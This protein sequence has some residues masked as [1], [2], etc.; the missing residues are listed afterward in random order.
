[1][2]KSVRYRKE[3]QRKS[4]RN[5]RIRPHGNET[6]FLIYPQRTDSSTW[7]QKFVHHL[8]A[9]NR[10]VHLELGFLPPS[11]RIT[12]ICKIREGKTGTSMPAWMNP[13]D[14]S[15]KK[16]KAHLT[17]TKHLSTGFLYL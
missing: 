15:R 10:F 7:E 8:P 2:H 4:T 16:K 17:C 5:K 11:S 1:M 3:K 14:T 13:E 6:T 12:Q 9:S